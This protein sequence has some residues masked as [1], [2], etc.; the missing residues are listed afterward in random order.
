MD[1][2]RRESQVQSSR[3]RVVSVVVTIRAECVAALV[4]TWAEL[5]SSHYRAKRGPD[6]FPFGSPYRNKAHRNLNFNRH[7]LRG[8]PEETLPYEMALPGQGAAKSSGGSRA[9][10]RLAEDEHKRNPT[11]DL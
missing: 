4:A 6:W 9:H 11:V 10:S 5:I 8:R 7:P 2:Y 1:L 3:Y